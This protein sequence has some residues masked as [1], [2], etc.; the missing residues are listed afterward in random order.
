MELRK[1]VRLND[2]KWVG[3]GGKVCQLNKLFY[4]QLNFIEIKLDSA[5][6]E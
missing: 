6:F 2:V 1:D 4:F 3:K 5:C